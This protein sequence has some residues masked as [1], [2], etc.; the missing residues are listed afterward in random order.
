MRHPEPRV[1]P[2]MCYGR[3]DLDLLRPVSLNMDAL[4]A[5]TALLSSPLKRARLLAEA[6]SKRS[7]VALAVDDGLAEMDFGVWEGQMWDDIPRDQID[8]WAQDFHHARPHGGESVAMFAKRVSRALAR[9]PD[10]ALLVC[11]VGVIRVALVQSGDP[12]GWEAK[13]PFE[14]VVALPQLGRWN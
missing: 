6:I 13:V 14:G 10:G 9:A 8:A 7:G 4:P 1:D 3:L 2:G 5:F 11:H 12:D